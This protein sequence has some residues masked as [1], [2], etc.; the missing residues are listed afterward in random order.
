MQYENYVLDCL[1]QGE[2]LDAESYT[3][4]Q[5]RRKAPCFSYGDISRD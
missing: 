3:D 4:Y 5:M 2:L 1:K